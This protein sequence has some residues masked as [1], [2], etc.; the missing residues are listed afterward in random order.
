[1][2]RYNA[3]HRTTHRHILSHPHSTHDRADPLLK[4]ITSWCLLPVTYYRMLIWFHYPLY[5]GL[6]QMGNLLILPLYH[7]YS[8]T[9]LMAINHTC[10]SPQFIVTN[11]HQLQCWPPNT[12]STAK[13]FQQYTV[14]LFDLPTT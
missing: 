14:G 6:D 12:K 4:A 1:M 2:N 8:N 5:W 10:T 9:E 11:V 7:S 3:R 13:S